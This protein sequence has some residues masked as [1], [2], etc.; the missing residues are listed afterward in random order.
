M[1]ADQSDTPI[2]IRDLTKNFGAVRA[3]DGLDLTVHGGEVHGFLGPNGAGK[4]TTIRILLGLVKADAGTVRLFGADPWTDGVDLH[5]QIAYVPGDVT[6][7]PSLTGGEIID[8]L[9][10]MR[11]GID[12]RRRAD[13]IERFELDPHKK[14]RTYSKGNRQKVS[15]ISAFS[16]QAR[17][18]L[19]DE[20]S[21]G[22]DPLMENVFQQCVREAR[23][24]GTT[25]L[26]SSHILAETEALCERVTIIRAGKTVET[27]SL[28]SMRHLSR[29]SIKA[30][31]TG[32]PGDV[33]RIEGVEDVSVDGNTLR[34]QV[35]SESLGELI[36]VLGDAG[37]SSLVSQPP[38]LEE[39]FLRH[40][41]TDGQ[42]ARSGQQVPA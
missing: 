30:E 34:A 10:R 39:L 20:P 7:W 35:D 23:D 40:Y 9:A 42:E 32:D 2:E 37:V 12:E 5:R 11:G 28:D 3:L 21:S 17:L 15:L 18:L 27:G 41:G 25:V 19:L 22:L 29:T 26:L 8:L 36:R 6:L 4:S 31:M 33:S 38:T 13:L 1:P 24:R 16:S 14:A